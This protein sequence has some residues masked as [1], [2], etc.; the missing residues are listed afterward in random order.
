MISSSLSETKQSDALICFLLVLL[1]KEYLDFFSLTL[2][3][4]HLSC[5]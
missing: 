2:L 5:S 1:M 3:M 4:Q